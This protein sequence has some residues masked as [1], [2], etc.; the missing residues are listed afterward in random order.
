MKIYSFRKTENNVMKKSTMALGIL[1]ALSATSVS[2]AQ[3]NSGMTASGTTGMVGRESKSEFDRMNKKGAADVA[4]IRATSAKL[5]SADQSLMMEVAK[6]GMK[7]LEMSKVAVQKASNEAV[8]QLAQ[9]EVEEQT[10]LSAKLKEIAQAKGITLPSAP[11]AEVQAAVTRLQA[12]SGMAFDRMYVTESGVKGH[13]KLDSVMGK[14]ES[15][16][17]DANLKSVAQAAH[18][19]VKN[20]L[21][22]SREIMTKMSNGNA[23]SR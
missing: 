14:V 4:A 3:Q 23:G 5:S 12:T 21:K 17:A 7:Q 13:E 16:A 1:I 22:V 18:P 2:F 11:D 15:S 19:L 8:R 10:G 6:G 20:H 9:A